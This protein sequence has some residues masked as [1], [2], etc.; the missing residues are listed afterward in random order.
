MYYQ[1]Q[2]KLAEDKRERR[3][4]TLHD[5]ENIKMFADNMR[6]VR[7]LQMVC[8]LQVEQCRCVRSVVGEGMQDNSTEY[9]PFDVDACDMTRRKN[10]SRY[11]SRKFRWDEENLDK[12]E[13]SWS[14]DKVWKQPTPVY[15]KQVTIV[16]SRILR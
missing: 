8:G 14:L 3:S 9:L 13:T 16:K 1:L 12:P 5:R 11:Y 4:K 7:E 6:R 2:T 10:N 15:E